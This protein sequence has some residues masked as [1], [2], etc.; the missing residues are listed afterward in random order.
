MRTVAS[1]DLPEGISTGCAA[2]FT[3]D[4]DVILCAAG[5]A[6]G[7]VAE[8]LEELGPGLEQA[9]ATNKSNKHTM[10]I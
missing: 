8:S 5:D 2:T 3:T 7:V 10:V 6:A 9:V 4:S 1:A